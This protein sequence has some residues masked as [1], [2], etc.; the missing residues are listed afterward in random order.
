MLLDNPNYR[1][2]AIP[3]YTIQSVQRREVNI[4]APSHKGR[5]ESLDFALQFYE[6]KW[7]VT[8]FI[9]LVMLTL[10]SDLERAALGNL[11]RERCLQKGVGKS[12][13][14]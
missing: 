13:I 10:E 14:S 11:G 1:S 7:S 3:M 2:I 12:S 6:Q 5:G 9:P 8:V 4:H